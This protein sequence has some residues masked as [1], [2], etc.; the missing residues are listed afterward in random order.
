LRG[1][2]IFSNWRRGIGLPLVWKGKTARI[3]RSDREDGRSLLPKGFERGADPDH[4]GAY[5]RA[6]R[7]CAVHHQSFFGENGICLGKDGRTERRRGNFDFWPRIAASSAEGYQAPPCSIS[8]GDEKGC[9]CQPGGILRRDHGSG[10]LR[11]SSEGG[12]REKNKK[13]R[14]SIPLWRW[15]GQRIS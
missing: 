2:I 12:Q 14:F 4:D 9:S 1:G 11:L 8:G 10:C 3:D 13:G 5:P 7:S 6:N 15:K